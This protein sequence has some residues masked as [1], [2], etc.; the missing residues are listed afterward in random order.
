ME[1]KARRIASNFCLKITIL[2]L[3]FC[4]VVKWSDYS[5]STPMIW[6][7]IPLEPSVFSVKLCLK[8]TKINKKEVA[9]RPLFKNTL[10]LVQLTGRGGGRPF[11]ATIEAQ[12]QMLNN[13]IVKLLENS[14]IKWQ[15]CMEWNNLRC[16]FK[17]RHSRTLFPY[18]PSYQHY[19]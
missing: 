8:R 12:I 19:W 1:R 4:K 17:L 7:R 16:F 14:K 2:N 15:R 3:S 6:V 9:V 5:P 11:N 18:L 10:Y 13:F